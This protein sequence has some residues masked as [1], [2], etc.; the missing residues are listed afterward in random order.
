MFENL[1]DWHDWLVT[2]IPGGPKKAQAVIR[3]L[4]VDHTGEAWDF[5]DRYARPVQIPRDSQG[6]RHGRDGDY[7]LTTP[8][9]PRAYAEACWDLTQGCLLLDEQGTHLYRKR[10]D[11]LGAATDH[12]WERVESIADTYCAKQGEADPAWDAQLKVEAAKITTDW[13]AG[14]TPRRVRR[15]IKFLDRVYCRV[16]GHVTVIRDGD[17]AWAA[18]CSQAWLL[19]VPCEWDDGLASEASGLL[20][21]I[22][23]GE[24]SHS[25][26]TRLFATP[27]LEPYKHLSY[28]LWGRGGNGKSLLL[29][30][31]GRSFP[32][33][34]A[35]VDAGTLLHGKGF[36]EQQEAHRLIGRLWAYDDD[37]DDIRA[38]DMI[39]LKKISTGGTVTARLIGRNSVTFQPECTLAIAT[40]G[41]FIAD[42]SAASDRRYVL[43]RMRDGRRPEEFAPLVE[44]IRAHGCLGFLMASCDLWAA[45][46]DE[47]RRDVTIGDPES[48]SE[49]EQALVDA[50]CDGGGYAPVSILRELWPRTADR[51]DA[52]AHLGLGRI[53]TRWIDGHN[54]KCVGVVDDGRFAPYRAAHDA[55]AQAEAFD[56]VPMPDGGDAPAPDATPDQ[57]GFE[58]DYV[59]ARPD[60]VAIGWKTLVEAPNADTSKRP[61][62]RVY[63][64]VPAQGYCVL[65]LDTGK[66][67]EPDGWTVLQ[68]EVG[69]YGGDRLPRTYLVGTP[70]GGAHLYYRIPDQL[71]GHLKDAVH[72]QGIPVDMRAERKGY[73]IGAGSVTD[74]GR[75]TLLDVPPDGEA[76]PDLTPAICQ[77]LVAHGYTDMPTAASGGGVAGM[78]AFRSAQTTGTGKGGTWRADMTPIP[79]GQRN[80]TLYGWAFGR[81]YNHRDNAQQIE[82]DLR[83]RG[84]LSGLKDSEVDTIWRSVQRGVSEAGS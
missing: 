74:A 10:V 59:A 76:M 36:E 69:S 11:P 26:L 66:H 40:N 13:T 3:G 17:P 67:G 15:G 55:P 52:L 71:V 82:A 1:P 73:V 64:V 23:D 63:A 68:R 62:S 79:E 47:P 77:W 5:L 49:E 72:A 84:R 33:S 24:A 21:G 29:G 70:S 14:G 75:Y 6:T 25:N 41:A 9:C 78:Q 54:V 46:G 34:C 20:A 80:S 39:E 18:A 57:Y 28:V 31:I 32:D 12:G 22:T 16:D 38:R 51:A 44:H 8:A 81:L 61:D 65:D 30:S 37:A 35:G 48:I 56:P 50:V 45:C 19:A 7:Q 60:K 83:E 43:V 58:C 27:L 2:P 42:S 4:A 53:G